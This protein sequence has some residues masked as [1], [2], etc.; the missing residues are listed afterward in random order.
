MNVSFARIMHIRFVKILKEMKATVN[1]LYA[2]L[3]PKKLVFN[4]S[5]IAI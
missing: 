5:A 3:A 4:R 1:Q 2:S